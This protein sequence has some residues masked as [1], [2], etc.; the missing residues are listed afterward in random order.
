[1]KTCSRCEKQKALD[2]FYKI[3]GKPDYYCKACRKEVTIA[4]HANQARKRK[5]TIAGCEDVHYALDMCHFHY[6]R[7]LNGKQVDPDKARLSSMYEVRPD[8]LKAYYNISITQYQA[9]AKN[10]CNVCQSFGTNSPLQ[11]D[12]DHSCCTG[13]VSCGLCVRGMVC[14]RCNQSIGKYEAGT[15][16]PSNPKIRRIKKYLAKYET[17]RERLG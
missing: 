10:G 4:S 15:I 3:K 2:A 5:C 13:K 6:R 9:M 8:K 12:H 7:N 16:N 14:A 11:V 17:R 1:M